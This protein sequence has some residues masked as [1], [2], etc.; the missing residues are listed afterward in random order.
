MCKMVTSLDLPALTMIRMRSALK[1]EYEHLENDLGLAMMFLLKMF[2]S[3]SQ[4]SLEQCF[5]WPGID[6]V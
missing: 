4:F 5:S 6:Y 2:A 3:R 1:V